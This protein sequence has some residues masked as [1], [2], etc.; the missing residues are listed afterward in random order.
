MRTLKA[1]QNFNF[2]VSGFYS[3][4]MGKIEVTLGDEK[5]NASAS[6]TWNGL[7]VTVPAKYINSDSLPA[8]LVVKV[9]DT[10]VKT[11]DLALE[12][13]GSAPAGGGVKFS[14]KGDRA[15]VAYMLGNGNT[16]APYMMDDQGTGILEVGTN[17][18]TG[19]PTYQATETGLYSVT[20]QLSIMTFKPEA[21]AGLDGLGTI[22]IT[23]FEPVVQPNGSENWFPSISANKSYVVSQADIDAGGR[24][25]VEIS[26]GV[27]FLPAGSFLDPAP[28]LSGSTPQWDSIETVAIFQLR[29]ILV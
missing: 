13:A 14:E 2:F 18:L 1:N 28:G 29:Q 22:S 20:A 7:D 27:A 23:P 26:N 21:S 16:L 3:R 10:L 4:Q 6:V 17:G 11:Y 9:G 15:A 19:R 12:E 25:I 8:K 5:I 24:A